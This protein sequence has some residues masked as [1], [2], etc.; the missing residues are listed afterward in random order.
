MAIL[1]T[2]RQR[3]SCGEAS[4]LMRMLVPPRH[5]LHQLGI[6]A[7]GLRV[8]LETLQEGAHFEGD[9]LL[10][11]EK[12]PWLADLG[13]AGSEVPWPVILRGL[14]KIGVPF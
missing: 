5:M 12:G 3:L 8:I 2:G 1:A 7:L 9:V 13:A 11:D 14:P 4:K 10:A 6:A